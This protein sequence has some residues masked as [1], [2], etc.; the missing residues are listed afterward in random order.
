MKKI[1]LTVAAVAALGLSACNNAA[2]D[3]HNN[4]AD[5]NATEL[6]AGNDV[7]D[8]ANDAAAVNATDNA[9]EGVGNTISGA[10]KDVGNAA[11]DAA[12]TVE[13]AAKDA[14]N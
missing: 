3:T 10:A 9:L 5:I 4:A 7:A 1:G 8:S 12:D 2:D 11:S 6:E 13:N 14:T